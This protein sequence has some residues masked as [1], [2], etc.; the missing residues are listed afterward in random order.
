MVCRCE[1]CGCWFDTHAAHVAHMRDVHGV[2][3]EKEKE[4][5]ERRAGVDMLPVDPAIAADI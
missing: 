4:G 1:C 5:V 3:V 2:D